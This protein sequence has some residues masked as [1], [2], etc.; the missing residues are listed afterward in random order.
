VV[1]RLGDH[2]FGETRSADAVVAR[3][4]AD[5]VGWDINPDEGFHLG[6]QTFLV[7]PDRSVWLEDSFNNRLLVWSPGRPD[8][9][10]R[11]VPVPWGA[12]ISDFALGAHGNVFVT[13]KLTD[14]LRFVL[15]RLD[16]TAGQLLGESR[17]GREYGGGPGGDS[18]PIIGSDSP[19]RLGP[20]RTLYYGVM[21]GLPGD[22]P[23]WMPVANPAG[24]PLRPGA[25]LRGIRWPFRPVA[26]GLRLVGPEYYTSPGSEAPHEARYALVDARGRLVRAWRILSRTELNFIQSIAPEVVGGEPVVVLDFGRDD[27]GRQQ[28][29]Y[30]VLRLGSHGTT[31][32]FSLSRDVWGDSTLDD[33]RVGPDGDLYQLATS[34]QTG[35]VVS[36]FSLR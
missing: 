35:I 11:A 1:V 18:Y 13:R 17:I 36:R 7:G 33:L 10:A 31:A 8:G 28:W 19:L 5:E 15:D 9:F 32:R 27:G 21:M 16:G 2:R 24:R 12:G 14:P 22:E 23:G 3:A 30:E 25:Q 20:D 29:E 4:R 34:P 6:P 26:G